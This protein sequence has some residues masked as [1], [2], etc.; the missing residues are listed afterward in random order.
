MIRSALVKV[1]IFAALSI[2]TFAGTSY[3]IVNNNNR[4]ANSVSAYKL[5]TANGTLTS[6][7]E[8]G[9]TGKSLGS[10][11]VAVGQAITSDAHC[12]FAIDTQ[13][14]DIAAFASPS[15]KLVG[16]F[17]NSA[18]SFNS[19]SLGGTI[20]VSP[21]GK[22]LYGA[23]TGT[24]N[25]GAWQVNP[26][27]SLTFIAAYVPS[28]AA[29]T[30]SGLARS[31][32]PSRWRS[33][34]LEVSGDTRLSGSR[35]GAQRGFVSGHTVRCAITRRANE[36]AFSRCHNPPSAILFPTSNQ[37]CDIW[38]VPVSNPAVNPTCSKP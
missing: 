34:R 30:Y 23:Y 26:N 1:A 3:V 31:K 2:S 9:T 14:N 17:S 6:Y 28:V 7:G 29:D 24:S 35:F 5:D 20:A 38:S 22:F 27:C 15:Y 16:K 4:T 36:A 32:G 13:S 8:V 19:R 37:L 11:I 10:G 25:I 12:L 33:E 21:N 18:V